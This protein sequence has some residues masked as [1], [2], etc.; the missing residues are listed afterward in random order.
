MFEVRYSKKA[1]KQL[2]KMDKFNAKAI[3]NWMN[4]NVNSTEDPRVHGKALQ[5]NL[6]GLW[7]YRVGDYRVLCQI[8][9]EKMIVLVIDAGHRRDIYN[10]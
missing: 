1:F 8:Q 3:V 6:K 4:K 7:R 9:D 2:K 10:S 5:S